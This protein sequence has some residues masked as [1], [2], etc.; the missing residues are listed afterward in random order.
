VPSGGLS[1]ADFIVQL[2]RGAASLGEARPVTAALLRH[3]A[4]SLRR[5]EP[6]WW[7]RAQKSWESRTFAHWTEAWTLLLTAVHADVLSDADSPLAPYFPSCGGTAEADPSTVFERYLK[8]LPREF[9]E[10][11]RRGHRRT[12]VPTRAAVW[13][14]PASSYFQ[15]RGLPYYLVEINSG[16]G[17]NLAADLYSSLL[18]PKVFAADLIAA[19]IGLEPQPLQ[20]EDIE[21]RRWLTASHFP[22]SVIEI[23]G[24][25]HVI[26]LVA[27]RMRE[28][29]AFIQLA[30]CDTEMA[31][32]FI[33]KN[34]PSDDDDV[35]LFVFNMATTSRMT[36][37]QYQ[38]FYADM[39][40][41]LKPW[42]NRGLWL[43]VENVRGEMYSTTFQGVLHRPDP[44]APTGLRSFVMVR[45]DLGTGQM[46]MDLPAGDRFL[47][48]APP[49]KGAK[50]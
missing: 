17:L 25:D 27:K 3:L 35:G 39:A 18:P 32:A 41:M 21:H 45:Y 10:Q 29:A 12:F 30:P 15:R 37:A 4:E 49:P 26:D 8:D 34:I 38:A 31:P 43:E 20:L 11:L 14:P 13:I 42:G 1:K 48:V 36:D 28:E 23:R 47:E 5:G 46:S 19:R 9:F 2:D 44:A 6:D 33:A 7:K 16:G 50:R 24:L 40:E 22:D